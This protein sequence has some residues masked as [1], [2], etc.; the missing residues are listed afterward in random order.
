MTRRDVTEP[1]A[2]GEKVQARIIGTVH[3]VAPRYFTEAA[4]RSSE[5]G[6]VTE[7]EF[8]MDREGRLNAIQGP[9]AALSLSIWLPGQHGTG[10]IEFFEKGASTSQ[11]AGQ[12]P[13]KAVAKGVEHPMS[14]RERP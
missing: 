4:P 12:Q 8:V 10:C 3:V 2:I 13:R 14:G 5:V 7:G 11:F 1:L 6:L 9:R